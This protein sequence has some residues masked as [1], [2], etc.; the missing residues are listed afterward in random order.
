[1]DIKQDEIL[2]NWLGDAYLMESKIVEVLTQHADDAKDKPEVQNKI[3][4]HLEET[5]EHKRIVG[6]CLEK[7]G[8]DIPSIRE[9]LSKIMGN[10]VG[11]S[12]GFKE[13]KLIKN[14]IA[15]FTTEHLEIATYQAIIAAAQELG[16][17]TIADRCNEILEQEQATADWLQDNMDSLVVEM[18]DI[19]EEETNEEMDDEVDEVEE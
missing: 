17:D 7:V 11:M 5:K 14:A 15:E 12:N 1:M 8:G 3:L 4:Q 18:I 13:D 10:F 9:G 2:I 16:E 6:E 19:K